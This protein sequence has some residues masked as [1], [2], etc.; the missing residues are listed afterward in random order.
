MQTR[1]IAVAAA[2]LVV[3]LAGCGGQPPALGS[4]TAKVTI[5]G[6][7]TG[8]PHL[9]RCSQTGRAWTI[10]TSDKAKGFTAVLDTEDT[11]TAKSVDFHDFGGFTGT[12]WADQIG[13]AEVTGV[14]GKYTITGSADGSFTD[15]PSEA[16]TATFRIEADC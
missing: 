14:N 3:G 9:V 2:V 16:V 1:R 7:D 10:E 6:K 11:I 5:D 13:K 4:T 8:N 15:K 12:Y